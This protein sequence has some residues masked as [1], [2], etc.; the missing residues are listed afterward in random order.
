ME[1][2]QP[3]LDRLVSEL[4][5]A[6]TFLSVGVRRLARN[7]RCLGKMRS[8]LF[9]VVLG[10]VA[11]L[12]CGNVSAQPAGD[13]TVLLEGVSDS[14]DTIRVNSDEIGISIDVS[15]SRYEQPYLQVTGTGG[16]APYRYVSIS[17]DPDLTGIAID[18]NGLIGV[19][20]SVAGDFTIIV[21]VK[22]AADVVKRLVFTMHVISPLGITSIG[23]RAAWEGR[24]ITPFEVTVSGGRGP[25]TYLP[26]RGEPSGVSIDSL[27]GQITGT[28]TE[29]SGFFTVTVT[30]EDD[31]AR[32][33]KRNLT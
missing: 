27:S 17:S 2:F 29:E 1:Q 3:V 26:L 12:V 14:G 23:P 10:V 19:T 22:D 9:S 30:V 21:T 13:L 18:A 5:A 6:V 4:G 11:T 15:R 32:F 7:S 33:A 31:G 20:P 24:A 25:Y 8:A 28:P 16:R